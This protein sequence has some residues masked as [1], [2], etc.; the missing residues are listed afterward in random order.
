MDFKMDVIKMAIIELWV[1]QFWSEIILV[2][3][4]QNYFEYQNKSLLEPFHKQII[5]LLVLPSN[6]MPAFRAHFLLIN[7]KT[8]KS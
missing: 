3:S 8:N 6:R 1:V 2:I 4:N 5:V 7:Q